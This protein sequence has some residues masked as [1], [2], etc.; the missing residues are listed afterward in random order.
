MFVNS[1]DASL[2]SIST[3]GKAKNIPYS[4][5]QLPMKTL[6]F[7]L[8][9]LI[10]LNTTL[11]VFG[12]KK[13]LKPRNVVIKS[14]YIEKGSIPGFKAH[15]FDIQKPGPVNDPFFPKLELDDMSLPEGFSINT[16]LS[17]GLF[18]G[19]EGVIA[20][21]IKAFLKNDF[22]KAKQEFSSLLA[23]PDHYKELATLWMARVAFADSK[24]QDSAQY[25]THLHQAT[26]IDIRRDAIYYS[27]LIT[28]K[29][30]KYQTTIDFLEGI[31]SKL[32]REQWDVR[33]G[34]AYLVSLV[35]LENWQDAKKFLQ[36]FEQK[37]ISHSDRYYKV[38][39][40]SGIIYYALRDYKLSRKHFS[41]ARRY[42]VSK[43][44]Y[45]KLSRNIAWIDYILGN[46]DYTIKTL[47]TDLANY[48]GQFHEELK[49]L[50]LNCQI[51]QNNWRQ[52]QK[53]FFSI[54]KTSNFYI[55]SAYQV[56]SHLK[57]F[58]R[59]KKLH[60][61]VISEKY[62]FP[63][64]K[65]NVALLNGN[66]YLTNAKPEKAEREYQKALSVKTESKERW[67]VKYNLGLSYLKNSS[68]EVA[69]EYFRTT[70]STTPEHRKPWSI[71]HQL[72]SLFQLK[73]YQRFLV[74][75]KSAVFDELPQKLRWEIRFMKA[76]A[77]LHESRDKEAIAEFLTIWEGTRSRDAFGNAI[78][79][80]YKN[81][82]FARLVQLIN[83]FP[84][85][86]TDDI[87]S[88]KIK[89]LLGSQKLKIALKEVE[90]RK[91]QGDHLI[92]LRLKVWFANKMY[93]KVVVAIPPLLKDTRDKEKRL[94]YYLSLGDSYF[95][96]QKY[97]KCKNQFYK[98]L[99][100]AKE[101]EERSPIIYNIVLATY[102]YEDY[103]SF[104]K[105]SNQAL[106]K[107]NLTPDIR[108]AL[109]VLL[110]DY[111][112]QAKKT[113]EA[114]IVMG[115]YTKHFSYQKTKI[116]NKRI[117]LLYSNKKYKKCSSLARNSV[118]PET[119]FQRKDRIIL[120]GYCGKTKKESLASL[121]MID[122]ERKSGPWEYRKNEL[123]FVLSQ[124][125]YNSGQ[126]EKSNQLLEK[127]KKSKM[128]SKQVLE[129][130]L[131]LASNNLLLKDPDKAEEELG[132]VN[133]YREYKKY[134]EALYLKAHIKRA[135]KDYHQAV[136]TLLRVYYLPDTSQ[137][138]KQR[139]LIS[140]SEIYYEN[141]LQKEAISY[142]NEV[143]Y[144][145]VKTH[146]SL[147]E[148]YLNL[149]EAFKNALNG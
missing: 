80:L 140:I 143:D 145:S 109:T 96:L 76:S 28:L 79:T 108:F 103:A 54:P 121:V 10:L 139:I 62:S 35:A 1:F 123:N 9:I 3:L 116:H 59:F 5:I 99:E 56:R 119:D 44:Y 100:L 26:D 137:L 95:S 101:P 107:E 72:Y 46:T 15:T 111:Y 25:F 64:M 81:K 75:E 42:F 147:K 141:K 39:E 93:D 17:G 124:V 78:K 90:K 49:Y 30:K 86:E 112:I 38:K 131:L 29:N 2:F 85:A 149:R 128:A 52:A 34:Y 45:Q 135:Q 67:L 132:D 55:Y 66:F 87:F 120:S 92:N 37:T 138:N 31:D 41:D 83:Q 125:Y 118:G 20:A 13:E 27:A 91:L 133:R 16:S 68:F 114:N 57:D 43:P 48:Q 115:Y 12:S 102:L 7:L 89:S 19:S 71:Y 65:F 98:A 142:L 70:L 32:S 127:L 82:S 126:F 36:A 134:V 14:S 40:I 94:T 136:R 130:R 110:T 6:R 129:S 22:V 51:R 63:T 113:E 73:H 97:V 33:I 77:L 69:E 50:R 144:K 84:E 23:K 105:E 74:L 61:Q 58:E 47:T 148:R 24:L 53:T 4:H 88:Y 117:Q 104:L 146:K 18:R 21:G 8:P 122:N 106:K 11:S 60:K